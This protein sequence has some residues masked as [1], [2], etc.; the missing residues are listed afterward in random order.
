M[1]TNRKLRTAL[2]QKRN[3]SPQRL[4][5]LVQQRK[6]KLP[7]STELAIYT[8]AHDSG[9]DVS[10]YLTPDETATVRA[11]V[12]QLKASVPT[13]STAKSNGKTTRGRTT[14]KPALVTIS[15]FGIKQ[16]PGMSAVHAREAQQM[17]NVYAGMYVFENSLRDVIERPPEA[18]RRLL[19]DEGRPAEDP[20]CRG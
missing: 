2:L 8:I 9:I 18:I 6:A 15:G 14:P 16:L 3:F 5:Q 20:G 17:S 19:V 10:K 7:M 13:S 12:A 1:A 11:L 4:S